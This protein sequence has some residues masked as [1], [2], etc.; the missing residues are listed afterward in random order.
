MVLL[1]SGYI[2]TGT[3]SFTSNTVT[4]TVTVVENGEWEG[5]GLNDYLISLSSGGPTEK[6]QALERWAN[7]LAEIVGIAKGDTEV[8]S[9]AR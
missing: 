8:I 1:S 6:R 2:I 7:R 9:F 5:G 3:Q 4:V